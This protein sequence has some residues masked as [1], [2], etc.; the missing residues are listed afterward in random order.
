M[1][2]TRKVFAVLLSTGMALNSI[3]FGIVSAEEKAS[4]SSVIEADGTI[5]AESRTTNADIMHRFYYTPDYNSMRYQTHNNEC[6]V[7]AAC[8]DADAFAA[9][10]ENAF[11]IS[12][13]DDNTFCV[14][15][16]EENPNFSYTDKQGAP[17]S[18]TYEEAKSA[19]AQLLRSGLVTGV[20]IQNLYFEWNAGYLTPIGTLTLYA[21]RA[22]TEEDFSWLDDTWTVSIDGSKANFDSVT[23]SATTNDEIWSAEYDLMKESLT[24]VSGAYGVWFEPYMINAIQPPNS[25]ETIVTY[26]A[27][28]K[29]DPDNDTKVTPDDAYQTLCYYAKTSVNADAA[30]TDNSDETKEAAAF[31]AADVN[32][33]GVV[34]AD[35]AYLIL[36]YYAAESVGGTPSW[37]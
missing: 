13:I 34:D 15:S 29:G 37:D 3:P 7:I 23:T 22:L 32:G 14:V 25:Y 8:A 2:K 9:A 19:A 5:V 16:A 1:K 12:A 24:Q 27:Q 36:R 6:V 4:I 35:D 31:A 20:S 30:F 11:T 28:T 21:D 10:F 17:P 26:T 18:W 33:D